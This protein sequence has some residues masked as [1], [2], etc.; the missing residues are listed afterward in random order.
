M[1]ATL[2]LSPPA[3]NVSKQQSANSMVTNH[4]EG[5]GGPLSPSEARIVERE[6][7]FI[8]KFQNPRSPRATE[9][10]AERGIHI[11]STEPSTVPVSTTNADMVYMKPPYVYW[12]ETV[13]RYVATAWYW[14]RDK[15][16]V[17]RE[18][19]DGDHCN[20]F[21]E[22][23]RIGGADGLGMRFNR[24]VINLGVSAKFCG[25]KDADRNWARFS[26]TQPTNPE[27]NSSAGVAFRKQDRIYK[28]VINPDN[29]MYR[30][31]VA[32]AIRGIPCGTTLQIYGR[33]AHTWDST[34]LTGFGVGLDG[35]SMSWS[36][37]K[38]YWQA[39]SQAGTWKR[40]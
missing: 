19:F 28:T 20:S 35:F 15:D 16:S 24:K 21:E 11:V 30:G 5:R 4:G 17:D 2:S 12:S 7:E 18:Y 14:W 1:V 34:S 13:D 10:L 22:V 25:R 38:N 40:C 8:G 29:N 9:A 26:C 36:E 37:S 31:W 6:L 23:C 33:Y 39:S 32:M 27:D 3:T